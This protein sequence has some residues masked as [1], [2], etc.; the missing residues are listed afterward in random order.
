MAEHFPICSYDFPMIFCGILF[1]PQYK[2]D[3]AILA[4][5]DISTTNLDHLSARKICPRKKTL[6]ETSLSAECEGSA[7]GAYEAGTMATAS[8][9]QPVSKSFVIP[10]PALWRC[11]FLPRIAMLIPYIK[12]SKP[13]P[14]APYIGLNPA[15]CA[16]CAPPIAP[17]RP[18]PNGLR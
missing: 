5:C 1:R 11:L 8:P 18:L 6:L 7:G 4:P 12:P 16:N 14:I 10:S 15:S 9:P 3:M 2:I 13:P 17:P